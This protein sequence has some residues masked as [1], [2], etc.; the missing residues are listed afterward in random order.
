MSKYENYI[1]D[2]L[3]KSDITFVKEK[4]FPD[5]RKGLY[6]YDFYIEN[7]KGKQTI[8]EIDGQFHFQKIISRAALLKQQEHDRQKN[9][10]CL[11]HDIKL[12]RIP[13]WEVYQLKKIED[14]FQDKFLVKSKWHN[15]LL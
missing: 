2:L 11:A 1:D 14:L 7:Y 10:Y 4:S 5:L 12:Y 13:Y 9:S 6:R 8:I 15:D 3:K